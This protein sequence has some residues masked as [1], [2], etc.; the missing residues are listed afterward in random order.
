MTTA[1]L[2]TV[3]DRE[4]EVLLSTFRGLRRSGLWNAQIIV[5]DDRST[6]DYSWVKPY[7]KAAFPEIRWVVTGDYGGFRVNGYGNPAKAFNMGLQFVTTDRVVLMS[8]DVIVTPRVVQKM[9]QQHNESCIWTPR[10][11]DLDSTNEYCGQSRFFPMPWFLA[12]PS[13]AAFDVGGWDEKYLDGL[14]YEDNDFVGRLALKLG[15]C[16]CDW[17]AVAYHQSHEQPA[18]DRT[19]ED[20]VAANDRN[21]QIT[22]AKWQGIPFDS[23]FTPFDVSRFPDP[24]GVTSYAFRG[25]APV[26]V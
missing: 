12:V 25:K 4:P 3:H 6:M 7:A 14:C 13:K 16:R 9:E 11:V 15:V 10:V 26:A 19:N 22:K 5:V 17:T 24:S 18:Y 20:V 1:V 21:R 2:M 8:S 23:E